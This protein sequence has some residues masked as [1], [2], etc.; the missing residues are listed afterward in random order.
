MTKFMELTGSGG[1]A[2][3]HDIF[4]GPSS[5]KYGQWRGWM[6]ILATLRASHPDMVMDHR[7]TA[8]AWGPWYQMAGSYDEP[9]AGDEN[10]ETY[11][12]SKADWG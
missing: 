7:Q 4:A 12:E 9:I 11:A 3:D 8:H 10:P 1:W 2:W 6:R 5:L